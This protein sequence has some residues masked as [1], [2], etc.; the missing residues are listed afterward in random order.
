M[1]SPLPTPQ[2]IDGTEDSTG[3]GAFLHAIKT[4]QTVERARNNAGVRL[5]GATSKLVLDVGR[6]TVQQAVLDDFE[7]LGWAR[8]TDAKPCAFCAL[9]ASRGPVYKS[10]RTAAFQAHNHCACMPAAVFSHDEA[11]LG[12]AEELQQ[13]WYQATQGH[14]GKAAIRAWRQYWDSKGTQ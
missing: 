11:W 7:A 4:G 3:V 14:S 12:N 13:Q 5:S 10:E 9:L 1:P 6:Q 8:V 2:L